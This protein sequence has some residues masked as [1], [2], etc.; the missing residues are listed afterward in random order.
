MKTERRLAEALRAGYAIQVMGTGTQEG[1]VS[2]FVKHANEDPEFLT[3]AK[4]E[5]TRCEATAGKRTNANGVSSA[6][7]EQQYAKYLK[8]ALEQFEK[9]KSD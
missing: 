1:A 9:V 3:A 5:L 7:V 8:A 4:A 2:L 6:F